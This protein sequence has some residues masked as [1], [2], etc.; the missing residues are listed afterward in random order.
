MVASAPLAVICPVRLMMAL[1]E[2]TDGSEDLFVLRGFI[3]RRVSKTPGR[4]ASRPDRITYHQFL[5]YMCLW[6]SGV[7]QL[8]MEAFR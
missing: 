3:G 1:K 7:M 8:S 2:H 6:F 4:T 5:H